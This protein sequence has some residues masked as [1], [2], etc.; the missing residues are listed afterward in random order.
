MKIQGLDELTKKLDTL[1][2]SAND[3]DGTHNVSLTDVLTPS[4]VS[5][6][7]RFA[8]ADQLFEA[9]GFNCDSQEAFEAVPVDELDAF[10]KSESSFD[11]WQDMLS[12]AGQE[13][14]LGKL[15]L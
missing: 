2:K 7:T 14:A 9:S 11:S 3:L 6:H 15:G 4:F 13:W 1:A 8:N 10:I 5:K 12:S